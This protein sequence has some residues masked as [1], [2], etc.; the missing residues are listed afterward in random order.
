M[1]LGASVPR[2]RNHLDDAAADGVPAT[3]VV[4]DI[5]CVLRF[6]KDEARLP[7]VAFWVMSACSLM[8]ALHLKKFV[9]KGFVPLK[10]K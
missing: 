6:A 3:C 10:G 8:A 7:A 1:S 4:S 2:L 5:E 9:D